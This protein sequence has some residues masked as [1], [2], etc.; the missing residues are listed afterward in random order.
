[1]VG[2]FHFFGKGKKMIKCHFCD[3]IVEGIDSAV[4]DDWVP[5][6]W[7]P[8]EPCDTCEPVCNECQIEFLEPDETGEL[9]YIGDE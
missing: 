4:A 2:L 3:A 8:G 5:S 9:A 7:Y 1:M 6:F